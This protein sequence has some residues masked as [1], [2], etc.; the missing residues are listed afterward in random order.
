MPKKKLKKADPADLVTIPFD[1]LIL[2]HGEIGIHR[3]RKH[4]FRDVFGFRTLQNV[5]FIRLAKKVKAAYE[6]ADVPRHKGWPAQ[7]ETMKWFVD[8][9]A[10]ALYQLKD[11]VSVYKEPDGIY[12]L[13]EGNHRALALY[14]LGAGDI[15][16]RVI[17]RSPTRTW[18]RVGG[19][20]VVRAFR[21]SR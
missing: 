7:R 10:D 6:G 4:G 11:D 14:I 19:S 2:S 13:A 16:A 15:R 1:K 17:K 12:A 18:S 20:S 3:G 21:P 5:P 8:Q 9:G